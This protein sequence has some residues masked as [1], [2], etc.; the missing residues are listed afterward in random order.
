MAR[1]SCVGGYCCRKCNRESRRADSKMADF[2]EASAQATGETSFQAAPLSFCKEITGCSSENRLN[3]DF[4][5][6]LQPSSVH[7]DAYGMAPCCSSPEPCS[8]SSTK[9]QVFMWSWECSLWA[10]LASLLVHSWNWCPRPGLIPERSGHIFIGMG[11]SLSTLSCFCLG[12]TNTTSLGFPI[13]V[14]GDE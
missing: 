6:V 7:S 8:Y 2:R 13:S 1:C 11:S 12:P 3:V 4:H 10:H 14:L 9:S 5:Y